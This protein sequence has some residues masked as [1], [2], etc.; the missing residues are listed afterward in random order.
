M[1]TYRGELSLPD[2]LEELSAVL[3][4]RSIQFE[5]IVVNDAS[6]DNTWEV[7]A[8]LARDDARVRGIDLLHNHGQP[9]ATMCGLAA[10]QGELV[11]TMDDDL[12]HRPD[13]LLVLL[14]ALAEHPEWDAVVANWPL[15]RGLLRD[16]GTKIHTVADRLAWG[17]PRGARHTAFRVMRR[18]LCE[19]LVAHQT[20]SPI[21]GPMMHRA[22]NRV[23][24]VEVQHGARRYGRSGFTIRDGMS[25]VLLNYKSGSTAPLRLLSWFGTFLSALAF[26]I[27]GAFLLRSLLGA[28][29]P[30]GWLSVMLMTTFLGGMVLLAVGVLGSYLEVVLREVRGS[31]RWAVRQRAGR[32]DE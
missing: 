21:V 15:Q 2:L 23:V 22:S 5:V 32:F 1:P 30:S 20:R 27:G 16:L 10:S 14:D 31:P 26:I 28:E 24:N 3:D 29:S 18:S 8:R 11:A 9:V 12:E 13:Q 17:T 6:P 19:S 25:R 7:V 4:E